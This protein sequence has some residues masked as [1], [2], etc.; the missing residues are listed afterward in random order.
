MPGH[1]AKMGGF[2]ARV[3]PA[4]EA[5]HRY[6]DEAAFDKDL[7]SIEPVDRVTL[8]GRIGEE[9]MKEKGHSGE[10]NGEMKSLPKMAAQPKSD[11]RSD[12][13]KSEE[14]EGN[15]ANSVFQ[16]LAGGMNRIC[17][18]QEAKPRVSIE[19]QDGWMQKRH[20]ESD[21]ARPIVQAKIIEPA[22]GPRPMRTIPKGHEHSEEK[23]QG[24][25]AHS[26]EPDV[27]GKVEDGD[28]HW[29]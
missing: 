14:I 16:W 23:I 6:H 4:Q 22:M 8:Q 7:A 24:D 17:E 9:A 21:I 13:H 11:G 2:I 20:R 5:D 26:H 15:G 19:K 10:I 25:H 18:I 27:G 1:L 28:A 29:H 3:A 12:D